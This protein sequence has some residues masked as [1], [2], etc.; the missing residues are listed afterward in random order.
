MRN[1]AQSRFEVKYLVPAALKVAVFKDVAV[2]THYDEHAVGKR[3]VYSVRTLYFD[4]PY[5]V[6]YY[7]K[8]AGVLRRLKFRIRTYTETPEVKF[9]EI[10]ERFNNRILKRKVRLSSEAYSA[11]VCSRNPLLL[12]GIKKSPVMGEF[13][14]YQMLLG[15]SPLLV[16]EYKRQPLVGRTD[17]GLRITFDFDIA[18]SPAK[19]LEERRGTYRVLPNGFCVLEVKFNQYMPHWVHTLVGK[20]SLQDLAYSKFCLG[21][22]E[23]AKKGVVHLG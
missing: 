12:N 18:V 13:F 6:A 14:H 10:K 16:I 9:L 21:L 17:R 2:M 8:M 23:L 11:I 20:F 4:S 3:N 5:Y 22:E 1:P 7:E 19:D 15:L